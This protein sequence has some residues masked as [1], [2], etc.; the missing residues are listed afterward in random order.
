MQLNQR[1][2]EMHIFE[3]TFYNDVRLK[4]QGLFSGLLRDSYGDNNMTMWNFEFSDSEFKTLMNGDSTESFWV[5][6]ANFLLAC[7][8]KRAR[9]LPS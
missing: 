8:K 3:C 6:L 5:D 4:F 2:D 1:E 9:A 7:K